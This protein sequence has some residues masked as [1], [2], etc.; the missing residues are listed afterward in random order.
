MLPQRGWESPASCPTKLQEALHAGELTDQ[1]FHKAL[2]RTVYR[3]LFCFVAEDRGALLDPSASPQAGER[4]LQYFST[5][6]LRRLSRR[7]AGGPHPDLWQAQKVVLRALGGNG[8][9]E[10]AVP[11]LGGLFDPDSREP[12]VTTQPATD[13]ILSTDRSVVYAARCPGKDH[14]LETLRGWTFA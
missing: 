5:A 7:R 11:A 10:I 2:L 1:A 9:A 14:T 13:L 12:I 6:R 4:Y 8:R 3:L